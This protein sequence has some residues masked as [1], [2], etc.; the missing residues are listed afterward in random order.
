MQPSPPTELLA[1]EMTLDRETHTYRLRRSPETS[2]QSCTQFV[3][4][5]FE[6]FIGEEVAERLVA[7][8]PRYRDRTVASL[9]TEWQQAAD[10]GT[11]IHAEIEQAIETGETPPTPRAREALR[12][13]ED[14]L[15]RTRFEYFVERIVFSQP[16]GIAGTIDL[17]ARD[18]SSGEW[19]LIDWKT[20]KKI[21]RRSYAGK[22]GIL[23]PATELEDSHVVKYGMQLSLYRYLLETHYAIVPRQQ[24]IVHLGRQMIESIPLPYAKPQL[25]QMLAYVAQPTR[26]ST[27]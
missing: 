4:Q 10:E 18:R 3:G 15:P 19:V 27:P 7:T 11:R 26:R 2:F 16:L 22:C 14:Q 23:G 24:M 5:F 21:T 9:L 20:N 8:S 17:L 1:E 6:P 25:Q 12:W 13:L